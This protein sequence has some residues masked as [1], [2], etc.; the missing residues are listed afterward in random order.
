MQRLLNRETVLLAGAPH[1]MEMVE[2]ILFHV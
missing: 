1:I 2:L